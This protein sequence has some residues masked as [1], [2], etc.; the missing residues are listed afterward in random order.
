MKANE[1][2][3]KVCTERNVPLSVKR[4]VAMQ[5]K[6]LSPEEQDSIREEWAKKIEA[7]YPY[8]PGREPQTS[9]IIER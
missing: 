2:Y 8:K 3:M 4:A 5:I 1:S 9:Q 6:D 7:T